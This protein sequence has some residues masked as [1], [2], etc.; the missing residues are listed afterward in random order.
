MYSRE[1]DYSPETGQDRMLEVV[2][3]EPGF[4]NFADLIS[5]HIQGKELHWPQGCKVGL[6]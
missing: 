3:I 1:I 2:S 5:V 4:F 6:F